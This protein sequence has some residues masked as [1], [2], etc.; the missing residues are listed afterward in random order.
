MS[1]NSVSI[2]SFL[3]VIHNKVLSIRQFVSVKNNFDFNVKQRPEDHRR[4]WDRDEY[5]KLARK[6][7]MDDLDDDRNKDI[8]PI[9]REMLKQR[10]YRVD[11]DS[12]L[13]KSVV[14]TK[15]TPSSQSGG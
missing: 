7:L 5:E 6:R 8:S 3:I 9:K 13:G 2:Y 14:I 12:K 15:A 1:S 11:L 4:K 10:D